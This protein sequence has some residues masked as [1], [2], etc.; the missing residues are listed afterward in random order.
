MKMQK[1]AVLTGPEAVQA[2]EGVQESTSETVQS[3]ERIEEKIRQ[4]AY[5]LYE[6]RGRQDGKDLDGWLTA[7]LE[8]AAHSGR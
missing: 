2:P 3:P 1:R 7:E 8:I 6:V 4:R 5:E